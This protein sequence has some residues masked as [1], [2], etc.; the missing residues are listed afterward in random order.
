MKLHVIGCYGPY[1][2][3]GG[4][5]SGYLLEHEGRALLMDCGAGIL[6]KLMNLWDPAALECVLLSHL[7]FDHAYGNA[8]ISA[9]T[10]V[11]IMAGFEE[12]LIENK[13]YY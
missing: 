12:K 6:G 9:A 2:N 3:A 8:A 1:P 10:G 11:K 4:A 13:L 5:A 7:H